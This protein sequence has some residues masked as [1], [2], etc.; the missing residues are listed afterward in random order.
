MQKDSLDEVL[1]GAIAEQSEKMCAEILEKAN[2]LDV[3]LDSDLIA[4]AKAILLRMQHRMLKVE[5]RNACMIIPRGQLQEL[6][7]TGRTIIWVLFEIL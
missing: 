6:L 5:L 4:Q 1:A 2:K 7:R 3:V